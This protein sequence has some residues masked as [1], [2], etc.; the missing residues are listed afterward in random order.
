[1][2]PPAT[3]SFR[4]MTPS[5]A[6]TSIAPAKTMVRSPAAR[7][8]SSWWRKPELLRTAAKWIDR[9]DNSAVASTGVK[10]Y[11]VRYGDCRQ[12]ANNLESP[13]NQIAPGSG[14]ANA[15]GGYGAIAQVAADVTIA[16]V[17]LNNDLQYGVQLFLG[18]IGIPNLHNL[19]AVGVNSPSGSTALGNSP[20]FDLM[21]G[22]QLTPHVIISAHDDKDPLESPLSWCS[23][24]RR[25][26]F[27]SASK[28]RSRQARRM[29]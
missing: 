28:C 1:M 4:Q 8:P 3:G 5:A 22:N 20:G 13:A 27:S 2:M 18:N 17:D 12:I 21:L 6:A 15:S 29:C 10:V 16:E 24:I 7:M 19:G 25:Q 14:A 9:L 23:I 26:A 11:R